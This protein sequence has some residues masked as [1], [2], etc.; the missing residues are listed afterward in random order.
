MKL[1]V[2]TLY[3]VDSDYCYNL[4]KL[5]VPEKESQVTISWLKQILQGKVICFTRDKCRTRPLKR[6]REFSRDAL[7][8]SARADPIVN[9]YLPLAGTQSKDPPKQ[10]L[11]MLLST[12]RWEWLDACAL[13]ASAQRETKSSWPNDTEKYHITPEY[14]EL[15][16]RYPYR[17]QP[18]EIRSS[19][20]IHSLQKERQGTPMLDESRP[21]PHDEKE[22]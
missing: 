13:N 16:L 18:R 21:S 4:L 9:Q 14:A 8:A 6:W 20:C 22:G 10:Y 2:L 19:N 5:A 15:L 17:K 3:L 11:V 1:F 12:L 7:L